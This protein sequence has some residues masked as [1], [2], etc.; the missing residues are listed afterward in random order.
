MQHVD[1]L[2]ETTVDDIFIEYYFL[3]FSELDLSVG[4]II[5]IFKIT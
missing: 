5:F 4:Q 2:K 1:L 3:L